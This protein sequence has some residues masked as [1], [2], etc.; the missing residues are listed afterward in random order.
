ME[1][2]GFRKPTFPEQEKQQ[3]KSNQSFVQKDFSCKK[4]P[5]NF[6][7]CLTDAE[8]EGAIRYLD[9]DLCAEKTREDAGTTLAICITLVTVLACALAYLCLY[10][11]ML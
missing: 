2:D 4:A 1:K 8:I 9:R 5:A 6:E 10:M 11:R 3:M 7:E